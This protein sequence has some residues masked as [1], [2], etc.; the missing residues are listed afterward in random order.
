MKAQAALKPDDG[1]IPPTPRFH[2]SMPTIFK[3]RRILAAWMQGPQAQT[4]VH[5]DC[6]CWA[7]CGVKICCAG[8]CYDDQGHEAG[9]LQ[10]DML[11]TCAATELNVHVLCQVA[12]ITAAL[13]RNSAGSASVS[14]R[15]TTDEGTSGVVL[16]GAGGSR[17]GTP[18]PPGQEEAAV[19]SSSSGPVAASSDASGALIAAPAAGG[20]V[21]VGPT[22]L[23]PV[24]TS[25]SGSGA[26][27]P[28][29]RRT[30]SAFAGSNPSAAAAATLAAAGGTGVHMGPPPHA[31][32]T[33]AAAS[34][35]NALQAFHSEP[36]PG[37]AAAAAGGSSSNSHATVPMWS[38]PS[39]SPAMSRESS[40]QG[41]LS[42]LATPTAAVAKQKKHGR[43][44]VGPAAWLLCELINK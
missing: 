20:L 35:P 15:S 29:P 1:S 28:P 33:S 37:A 18:G 7:H 38:P 13:E 30:V 34:D 39:N 11:C 40:S 8:F 23:A 21:P 19:S 5:V 17:P 16:D 10:T 41:P 44:Q 2:L 32:S 9:T 27:P 14:R 3:G 26:M 4:W 36:M 24:A 42:A 43:F 22:Q 12:A 25:S 6:R 31:P